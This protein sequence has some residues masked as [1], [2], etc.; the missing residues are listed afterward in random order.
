MPANVTS[1]EVRRMA[2]QYPGR[3]GNLFSPGPGWWTT[4][5]WGYALDNG[6]FS[7]GAR[8]SETELFKLYDRAAAFP[9]Q[10]GWALVPDVLGDWDATRREWDV[11]APRIAA[12]GWPLALAVQDGSTLES[13]AAIGAD[14]IFVGGSTKFKW[15]TFHKWAA[16]FPRVHVGRVNAPREGYRCFL[17]GV[18]SVD[19]TGW[20][21]TTR[22]RQGLWR[23]LAAMASRTP[24]THANLFGDGL[25]Q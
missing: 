15:S 16:R 8:W 14:V 11:W 17:A 7:Q 2:A 12:Y 3:L 4:P 22:Q 20:M 13:A 5:H 18:E 25:V 9:R 1:P 10:P 24:P 19:G 23:L 6:R 21:R